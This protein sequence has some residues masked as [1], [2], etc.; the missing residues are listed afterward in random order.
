MII[1]IGV[2]IAEIARVDA[3][4][5]KFGERFARRILTTDE[6]VEYHRRKNSSSFLALRFAAKE[7]VAKACGTGIGADLSFHSMQINNDA[8][9]KPQLRFL[10]AAGPLVKRLQIGNSLISLSDEKHYVVAMAVLET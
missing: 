6:L 7:A 9:G 8:Q 10:D 2:D 5:E 1:G 3:L 4:H